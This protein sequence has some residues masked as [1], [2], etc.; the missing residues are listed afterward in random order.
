MVLLDAR[1][2]G[3]VSKS[4][5]WACNFLMENSNSCERVAYKGPSPVYAGAVCRKVNFRFLQLTSTHQFPSWLL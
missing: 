4:I 5:H 2:G 1:A 3:V